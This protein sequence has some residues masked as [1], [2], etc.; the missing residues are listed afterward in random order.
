M[1]RFL[2]LINSLFLFS[3]ISQVVY[4]QEKVE[5]IKMNSV[6]GVAVG[7]DTESVGQVTQRAINEA[8]VEALKRTGIVKNITS[9][10]DYFQSESNEEY[11][12]L[13]TSD[14]L[15]DIRGAVKAVEVI[16]TKKSFDE[17]GRLMIE[18]EIN[19]VVLKYLTEKDIAFDAW[20]DGVGM[21]YQNEENLRFKLKPS[22]DAYVK[23]FIFS[24]TEAFQLFP[25]EY[26]KSYLLR[27]NIE[28]EFPSKMMDYTLFTNK[29]TEVHRMIM[30]F[31]KKNIPYTNNI[32]YKKIIDWIFSIP[33]DSRVV[34]TFG[35][36]VVTENKM[37]A[38]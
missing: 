21:F 1:K 11:E 3:I 19:C 27:A 20:V 16:N 30:V 8:K 35:F 34:K 38:D 6:F 13:F 22:K 25:S 32:E 33:P 36:N 26:E 7:G 24:E 10:T 28:Y 23:I 18:V 12:E 29:K 4:A 17:A 9:F 5:E 2:L 37:R 15:A 14:I 31:M